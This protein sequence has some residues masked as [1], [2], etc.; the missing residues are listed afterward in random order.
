M[1]VGRRLEAD[2]ALRLHVDHHTLD[3][4][5]HAVARQRILPR[6]ERR[7]PDPRVHEVHLAHAALVLLEGGDLAR[8]GRPLHHRAV[9]VAPAGV[10]GRIAVV[11]HA[12]GRELGLLT[13]GHVAHPEVPVA[14]ERGPLG[15]GRQHLGARRGPVLGLARRAGDVAGEAAAVDVE[16]DGLAVGGQVDGEEGQLRPLVG[17]ARR[18][19]QRRRDPVVVEGRGLGPLHRIHEDELRAGLAQ[20]A[21]PEPAVRQPRRPHAGMQHERVG[22]VAQELL[23]AAVVIGRQLPRRLSLRQQGRG[24]QQDHGGGE[25]EALGTHHG[26]SGLHRER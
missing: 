8:V 23:G 7:A 17:A 22:V 16:R 9:A 6:L 10:V 26:R 21:V 11:L 14:D 19:R 5:H 25:G 18:R 1:L 13:R 3:H 24:G 4:R 2:H 20:R 12:V 15:V